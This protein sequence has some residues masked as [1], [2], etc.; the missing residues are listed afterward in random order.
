MKKWLS[1]ALALLIAGCVR[2]LPSPAPIPA[3]PVPIVVPIVTAPLRVVI[4]KDNA[5]LQ[6]LPPAQ[7]VAVNSAKVRDYC[8]THCQMG[9]DGKTPE[10]RAYEWDTDT[11][12][13]SQAIQDAFAEAL[14]G[15]GKSSGVPWLV[16][17]NGSAGY[18][19]PFPATEAEAIALLKKY[20]GE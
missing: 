13:Q 18:S 3:P 19:G 6:R 11:Q 1:I 2:P 17:N 20:G 7:F 5:T 8:K 16:V 12:A 15:G 10:F 4:V 14:R 9:P